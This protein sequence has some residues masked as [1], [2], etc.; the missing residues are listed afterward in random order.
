MG[1]RRSISPWAS[2]T[3]NRRRRSTQAATDVVDGQLDSHFVVDIFQTGSGTSTNMNANEVIA[4]RASELPGGHAASKPVHPN[5]H[6]NR[7]QSSNDVIP[8]ALHLAAVSC[9][10]SYSA[11]KELQRA[12]ESQSGGVRDCED[13]PHAFAGR[14]PDAHGP[15]VRRV[16]QA[17]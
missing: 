11:L 10:I 15:G 17:D 7:G 16:C 2:S 1:G 13:R 4:H 5:D 3:R 12:L 6:V 8:T 14:H 9:R